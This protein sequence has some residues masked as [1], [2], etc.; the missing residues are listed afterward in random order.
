MNKQAATTRMEQRRQRPTLA[1]LAVLDYY[2]RCR[3]QAAALRT[4][5]HDDFLLEKRGQRIRAQLND[6]SSNNN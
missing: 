3:M 2:T 4:L 6:R 5:T 1:N